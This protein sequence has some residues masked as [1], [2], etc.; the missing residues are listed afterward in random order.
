MGA[1]LGAVITWVSTKYIA[2]REYGFMGNFTNYAVTLSQILLVGLNST[3]SVYVHRFAEN[4][5]KKR[6]LLT[7]TFAI[8]V[9]ILCLVTV[10]YYMLRPWILGH[11]QPADQ[12]LMNGYFEWLPFYTLLFIYMVLLE[13]YL[14]SQLKVAVAAFMRE[15]AYRVGFMVVL[16]LFATGYIGFDTLIKGSILLYA[17]PIVVMVWLSARTKDFGL[18]LGRTDLSNAEYREMI[19]FTWYHFLLASSVLLV[20][21]MDVMLLPFYDHGGFASAAVYR[22]ALVLISFLQIPSKAL[23]PASY[24]VLAKAFTEND[25]PKAADLFRRSSNNILIA[26]VG[27]GLLLCCNLGNVLQIFPAG[28]AD[29]APVFLILALGNLVN[30]ATGMNDQVLSITNYY[31]FNFYLSLVLVVVLFVLIRVLVPQYSVFGAAWATAIT[32]ISFNTVKCLFI[33]KKLGMQPFSRNTLLVLVAAAPALVAGYFL[34]HFFSTVRHIYIN[35][36][37]DACLRSAVI[38]IVYFIMLL[39]LRP[40]ADL[41]EY[42]AAIKKN[43][44]LF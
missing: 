27:M 18:S 11:F 41:T 8:P 6:A 39:W 37:A 32:M 42:L 2:K 26:T 20:N 1:I 23:I 16:L 31:K 10:A 30:I 38:G 3:L 4:G 21:Y 7:F 15:V 33:W 29:L 24:T 40:S 17:M 9:A 19:H 14:A 43:K 12:P 28:Y 5:R 13:Q 25:L 44:R 22:N 36:F 35:A 34:P